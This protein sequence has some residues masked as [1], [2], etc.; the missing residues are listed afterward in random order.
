[1]KRKYGEVSLRMGSPVEL[2]EDI[3][4]ITYLS[5]LR[6]DHISLYIDIA[7]GMV[8]PANQRPALKAKLR[9]K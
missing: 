4:C 3:Y 7:T 2:S 9:E 5:M 6:A 1:M 8:I